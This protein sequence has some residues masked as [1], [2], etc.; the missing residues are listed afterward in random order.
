MLEYR[1]D[2]DSPLDVSIQHLPDQIN[3]VLAHD[4]RYPQIVVH[5]LVYTIEW[6]LLVDNRVKQDAKSPDILLFAAVRGT[7]EDFGGSVICEDDASA[8]R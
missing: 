5:D 7:T 8:S 4:I 2:P 3:T 1:L 6:V